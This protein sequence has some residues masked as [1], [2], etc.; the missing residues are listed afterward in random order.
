MSYCPDSGNAPLHGRG[1]AADILRLGTL[2]LGDYPELPSGNQ[3]NHTSPYKKEEGARREGQ[4]NG[5]W[6][7]CD[8]PPLVSNTEKGTTRQGKEEKASERI[9]PSILGIDAHTFA[10]AQRNPHWTRNP[11]T[12]TVTDL[13]CGERLWQ[14]QKRGTQSTPS[15]SAGK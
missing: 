9:L 8:P 14:Q 2:R 11:N 3:S 13:C 7:R 10:L 15:L 6:K 5:T 12:H 4:R 1:N